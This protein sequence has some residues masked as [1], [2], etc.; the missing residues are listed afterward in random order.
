MKKQLKLLGMINGVVFPSVG[1]ASTANASN[2][3]LIGAFFIYGTLLIMLVF[4]FFLI[5]SASKLKASTQYEKENGLAWINQ[6]LYDFDKDQLEV[7]IKEVNKLE[8]DNSSNSN[9]N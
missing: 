6:K 2:N 9:Q 1:F 3:D 5:K 7:L 4:A 8:S